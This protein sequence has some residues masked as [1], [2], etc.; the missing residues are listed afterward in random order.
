MTDAA[1][2]P[3]PSK[4]SV[5]EDFVDIFVQPS[6]VFERRRD[7]QFGL[8]LVVLAV[9]TGILAFVLYNGLAPIMDAV[10]AK[11]Q[12]AM[13]AKNPNMTQ[14]QLSGMTGFM[15]MSSKYG[16]IVIIPIAA[17]FGAILIW[18]VGKFL[19]AKVAFA[20]AMMIAVYSGVP[21][22][23][24]TVVTA[25][26]GL[27]LSPES[28][29]SANSVSIGPARFLPDSAD[30]I[31][32]TILVGLDAFTIWSVVLSAIGIAVVARVPMK[33]AAIVAGI[34]WLLGLLPA[35]YGAITQAA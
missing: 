20:A 35:L 34:A 31:L 26:Q 3:V 17:L 7:G 23:V 32:T 13:L 5:F 6:A 9:V 30:P 25:L 29:T 28:I 15:E 1:A 27:L 12:A 19:D 24:Q 4:L 2:P 14:E 11:Q 21:R 16:A 10:I 8:A 18:L 22:V 33:C